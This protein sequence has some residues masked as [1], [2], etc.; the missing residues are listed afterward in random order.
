MTNDEPPMTTDEPLRTSDEHLI[1]IDEPLERERLALFHERERLA[2]YHVAF[3]DHVSLPRVL[4]T[5]P[6][7]AFEDATVPRP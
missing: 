3:E 1:T 5:W 4:T 7:M 6:S 2:L